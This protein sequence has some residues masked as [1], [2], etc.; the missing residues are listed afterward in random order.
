MLA[1]RRGPK[2]S[3]Q[4][5]THNRK[6]MA[7]RY[8]TETSLL[9]QEF[10]LL[11][12]DYSQFLIQE[13]GLSQI[14]LCHRLPVVRQFLSRCFRTATVR[15][16]TLQARDISRFVLCAVRDQRHDYCQL[17]TTTLRSFLDFLYQ[18]GR[19][20]ISL[21]AAVP[22][23]ASGRP[24][25]LPSFLEPKQIEKLLRSCDRSSLCGRR[26]FAILL[27]LAR[28]GLRVH[29]VRGLTLDDINWESGEVLVRGKCGRED[30]LPLPPDVGRA[31]AD[32]LKSGRP[33]CSCR[34]VFLR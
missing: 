22:A 28:L 11:V 25:D 23:V 15:L 26:D 34:H 30:R 4:K 14:T 20:K 29:E 18:N 21:R 7:K 27:L 8:L 3:R 32:Y 1:N 24:S 33:R 10:D 31:I 13:R 6:P 5:L 9:N 17:V 16:N 19:L 12:R 2:A